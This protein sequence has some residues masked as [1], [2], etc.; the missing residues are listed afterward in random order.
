MSKSAI[1]LSRITKSFGATQVLKEI[2]LDVSP[3]EVLVLI[4]ASGSGKSTVLRIMSGLETAD[5]GEIWVNQV[6]LH[7]RKRSREICGH[8]GMVFQQFNLF[9]HKTALGNVTLA[10]IKAQKLSEAEANK[11]GMAALTRV[12]LAERAHHYPAQLS[13]GQQQRVAIARALAVEPKIMFFDEATSA[14]DPELVGEVMEVMRS[15]AREGMT[16]VVVTHEM[17]FARKTA[18]RVVFMDQG[19]IAE[20][21]S[22]EQIFVHPQNP[23]TQQFLS[24]VLEH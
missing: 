1:T 15:L 10:L 8:V 21:G 22:P 2:S 16:M 20:Q 12:G 18:D 24:R 17:G 19:V 11:R 9:P 14:L 4:G 7:D 5:G 13:G 6:P 3:G 23:R